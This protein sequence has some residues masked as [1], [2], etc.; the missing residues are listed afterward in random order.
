MNRELGLRLKSPA[1]P[2]EF[3]RQEI[4]EPVGLDVTAAAAALGVTRAP[5]R[6]G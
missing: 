6:H 5:R 2:G 1:H 3:I 4:I